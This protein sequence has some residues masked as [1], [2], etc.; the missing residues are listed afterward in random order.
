MEKYVRSIRVEDASGARFEMHEY[1]SDSFMMR[2]RRFQ[3]DT[4]ESAQLMNDNT[5]KLVLTG[6]IL[7]RI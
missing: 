2:G 7:V 3:L 5:F 1:R 6:E 4:G